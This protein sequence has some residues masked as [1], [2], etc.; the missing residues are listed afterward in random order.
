M[1]SFQLFAIASLLVAATIPNSHATSIGLPYTTGSYA[2][3][4][5]FSGVTFTNEAPGTT[6][7]GLFTSTLTSVGGGIRTGSGDRLYGG[8][9][10][11]D[12][13]FVFTINVSATSDI[14]TFSLALK[15]TQPNGAA[16]PA[17]TRTNFFTTISLNG[18]SVTPSFLGNTG[19]VVTGEP[20]GVM[21]WT[22]TG[23]G[24]SAGDN[25]VLSIQSPARSAAEAGHVS[26]DAFSVQAVPEPSTWVMLLAGIG[27]VAYIKRRRL[28]HQS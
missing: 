2:T 8:N 27:V 4:D 18:N 13:A 9:G 15:F 7:S 1:K 10:A 25:F 24:F 22:W 20:M 14:H 28:T 12:A 3:W 11:A 19:E 5:T 23:L 26:I 16:I 17:L 6:G 21:Q